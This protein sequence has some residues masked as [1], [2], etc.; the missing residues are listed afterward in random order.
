MTF[1]PKICVADA[2][3]IYKAFNSTG[4]INVAVKIEVFNWF[5]AGV[6]EN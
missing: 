3:M 2:F 6:V 1:P 5:C 4:L